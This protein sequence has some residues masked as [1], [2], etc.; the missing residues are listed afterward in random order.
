M[1]QAG[2]VAITGVVGAGK[3]TLIRRYLKSVGPDVT[4]GV[5][6]NSSASLGRLMQWVAASFSLKSAGDAIAL[7]DQFIE[8]LLAQYAKGKRTVLVVDEAQNLSAEML[9]DLRMLSNVNNEKDQLLQIIL[10]GQPELLETL[11]RPELRQ[12]VQRIVIYYHLDA[13]GAVETAGYI[14]HRLSVVGGAPELF[15]DMACAAVYYFTGGVPRLINL[16][17]DQALVYGYSDDLPQ[18]G[19]QTV[20]TVVADRN[21]SGLSAFRDVPDSWTPTSFPYELQLLAG[22][23]GS[24]RPDEE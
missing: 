23:I 9:E 13:L 19:F 12:L 24:A 8:F 15:D 10:V 22:E 3:T 20:T 11:K 5:I 21:Q 14:R 4:V 17:C 7:H 1:S 2:F 6:T 16:L 18:I